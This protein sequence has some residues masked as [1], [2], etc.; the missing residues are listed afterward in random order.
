MHVL[1]TLRSLRTLSFL[2]PLLIL[3][4]CGQ[5][6]GPTRIPGTPAPP[7][8]PAGT[9]V[10]IN[11]EE[12]CELPEI[13]NFNGGATTIVNNPDPDDVN[14]TEKV[15]RMQKFPDEP[16]GGTKIT[17][18]DGPID[19]DQGEF[20]LLKIWSPREV[21]VSFKLEEEGNA[22]GGQTV[23]V[24]HPGGGQWLELCYDFEGQMVPPP[25]INLTIIFDNGVL[26]EADTDPDNWTFYYDEIRQVEACEPTVATPID[27]DAT[28]FSTEGD[29]TL[30]IPDDYA[31][32]TA[33]GSGSIIDPMYADDTTYNPVLSVWSGTGYGANV[34]QI[35]FIGFQEGFLGAYASVDFKVKGMP[36]EVIFVKLFDSVDTLRISLTGSAFSELLFDDWYQ[37]S[38]PVSRFSDVE[39]AT[40][41]VFE[42][43]DTSLDQF[44]MLLTDIGFSGVGTSPPEPPFDG[45]LV[46]NGDFEAGTT[47][48]LEGVTNAIGAE[49][50]I[51]DALDPGNSVYFID[52]TAAGAAS[53]VNL[54]QRGISITPGETYT[55]TFRARSNV[56]RTILAGI[57]LS[58][59]DFSNANDEVSLTTDWQDFTVTLTAA[60]FGDAD[61]RVLFD[62]GAAIGE[63]YI[64]DVRL[65]VGTAPPPPPPPPFDGGLVTNGDFEAGTTPWLEGVTNAIGAERI[66]DDALDP[67][68]S[69]YFIDVTAAGAASDVNL[70]QRG[71]SITPGE[72]YTLTFR[73]RSNVARPI[74]AGIGLSGGDF[75]NVNEE[76]SLTTDW[77]DFTVNLT[78]TGFGDADSR[79]L[80]DLGAAI[81][82]V[83]I[84]DVRLVV[85]TPPPPPPPVFDGG[86]ITNGGFE[87]GQLTPWV[88]GSG[89][90]TLTITDT[91][92]NGGTFSLNLDAVQNQTVF[93]RQGSLG[94]PFTAG[95]QVT[96]SFDIK[97]TLTNSSITPQFLGQGAP[98]A[99]I[100]QTD[101]DATDWT[102]VSYDVTLASDQAALELQIGG[103]CG[104]VPTCVV[105]VFIDNVRVAAAA[106]P[107]PPPPMFDGG[108]LDN[109]GFESG[110]LSPWID[111]SGGGVVGVTDTEANG[112]SFSL[113]LTAGQ[114]QTVFVRQE[115]LGGPYM[116]GD[117]ITVSFD[118]KGTLSNSSITPQLLGQGAPFATIVQPDIEVDTWTSLSYDVTLTADQPALIFQIGGACGDVP[119]C[120]IDV[121]IDNV[122]VA[123]AAPPPAF[124]GG[125]VTN[126]D[127][128]AGTTPWLEGVTNAIGAARIIDDALDPGNNVYFVDVTA[129]G[130][131]SDV[132][133]SQRGITITPD[134]SY[135]LTFRARSN[136]GRTILAGIGLSGGDFSNVNQEVTLTTAW[137]DFT[138]ELTATGFGDA[139]SRVL[140][141]LGAQVGE[142]YID[143]VRLVVATPAFDGGLVTN[144]DF[145]AGT[146][147][148]LEG[149]TNAIG[150][151]RI[152]DDALDPGN[153]VYFVDV[154]AAGAA[155][156][157][158]L[159][160]RGIT[161]T[162]D[163]SYTL[164]FRARSNVG[165]TILAGI[166][167]SG[168]DFS[169]VNQEV[170]LTT[171]WQDFTVE[172]TA[173]GFGDAD[174]RVLFDLGAQVGEVYIDNVRLVVATPAFDGGLISNGDFETG[175]LAPWLDG[176]G[177][178][179]VTVTDTEANG[180]T[181]SLNLT[182]GQ[183]Q[184]VFVRQENLGG[185]FTAGDEVTVA[186]DI[187]GTL[188]N[189]S[190]TPQFLGQGA[191][192][193][194]I[195]QPDIDM[196]NWTSVSY[197]VTLTSDQPALSLQ[198]GG[199]CGDVMGCTVDVFID[200]VSVQTP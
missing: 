130:A 19:F 3:A 157:V 121:F 74:L 31:E 25:V 71:I 187:K 185:P 126:G 138:V 90:G 180:G 49:R 195:V 167:L 140:F 135:T 55:L 46:T 147:P 194:T 184:T 1:A 154:A 113:N 189:S 65:V 165:R 158:N 43:D 54:S 160:Q 124:D 88:N 34:A 96:V 192:F 107:P 146:T 155:S 8:P 112:G 120:V 63:V 97:G 38:I 110:M 53:D 144:G 178:G 61:S 45:G 67:G 52:V 132:N 181:F 83:Y 152:I 91:E 183:L 5:G 70:S 92:A 29:P 200:N 127:F 44:R 170:T 82:E 119:T 196:T 164:T 79:V 171:A 27:P 51:D 50:I 141:D 128:E 36:N 76:V 111:G 14:S 133:L 116:A 68:N 72:T 102:S 35:G 106:P 191:P 39:S 103:A 117:E 21:P 115:N 131:A 9:C 105:D 182:A 48:W 95:N 149:V 159:S 100:V 41:I 77:Q 6:N 125:L 58:G 20:Y 4:G 98:F 129:A 163:E 40:G 56:A 60:G 89:G 109:G 139:D 156:D 153:N 169:N 150:A 62:L 161:V 137:Q 162:P 16:F 80:F 179:V 199:A 26:G 17:P 7:P 177:G 42:S 114:N 87:T 78:A 73:A 94:G 33:F 85:G 173:T 142:V 166:G 148:W 190:I 134:E 28:L 57:G 122:R 64:D 12:G 176:S 193:A 99:T 22:E 75:S 123:A 172:L 30:V 198:I 15:A 81:G 151:A 24:T 86:L 93:V 2:V 175:M 108:L 32:R 10:G 104:D 13:A 118:I 186:F 145:E 143:N 174:S 23:D 136:V 47:P 188:T 84:D 197:D 69:V 18:P 66:I 101:I 11:F 59:G 168:G 37:V